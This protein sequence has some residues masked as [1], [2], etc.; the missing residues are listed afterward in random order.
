MVYPEKSFFH[1]GF[2]D[3]YPTLIP[4]EGDGT[5][6]L[7]S[8]QLCRFWQGAKYITLEGAEHLRI[9]GDD[10]REVRAIQVVVFHKDNWTDW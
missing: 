10:R 6:H 8:L 5:V 7:R 3:Q 2:P 4:G 9:V 1:K